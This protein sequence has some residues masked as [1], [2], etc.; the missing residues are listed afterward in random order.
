MR[1]TRIDCLTCAYAA[2]L[3]LLASCG[4]DQR[5]SDE[6]GSDL[7]TPD[8]ELYDIAVAD[9]VPDVFDAG[10]P[11]LITILA[12]ARGVFATECATPYPVRF[13]VV[14]QAPLAGV[15]LQGQDILAETGSVESSF[16]AVFGLNLITAE[17][18]TATGATGRDHRALLCGV[19]IPPTEAVAHASD[20][21]LGKKALTAI[22]HAGAR[23]FDELDLTTTFVEDNP[24]YESSLLIVDAVALQCDLGTAIEL[25]PAWDRLMTRFVLQNLRVA[26]ITELIG[27]PSKFYEAE[28]RMDK[29][30]VDGEM[31]L[32]LQDDGSI[33]ADLT[34]MVFDFEN[35]IVEIK[36]VAD[37]IL[38]VFPDY[39]ETLVGLIEEQL[40]ELLLDYV[41]GAVKE[42][43]THIGDPIPL[44][45][46]DKAFEIRFK[47]SSLKL[48]PSGVHL[49]LD[50]A[51]TG[52]APD[53]SITSPGV[54]NTPGQEE[55]PEVE[56]VRF[57]IKDDF[58]NAIFHEAWR[59]GMA[60]FTLDQ[61][62]MDA[63][64]LELTLVA[65]FL[66]DV[67]DKLPQEINPE[68]PIAV[69]LDATYPPVADMDIPVS[70]GVRLGA[71]D[72][73]LDVIVPSLSDTDP[74]ISFAV[75]LR[76]EGE[77]RPTPSD[78]IEIAMHAFDVSLDVVN[79]D[80][81]FSDAEAYLESTM[82]G[83]LQS[84]EPMMASLLG[85]IPLPSF[86]GFSLAN[87]HVGTETPNGGIVVI[88]G[89]I[90]EKAQ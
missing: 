42:A 77:V 20:L 80:G 85:S 30:I 87:L 41:P 39:K 31:F 66:G 13:N 37:D 10:P 89:D 1:T 60:R 47:P 15:T 56:G 19:Y 64:K 52:L 54:L 81:A 45:V 79:D 59:S 38:S 35:L 29:V 22:G 61:A 70:G 48:T 76:I 72:L 9:T 78:K 83:L 75:T 55:W 67:L 7:L 63:R 28:V 8:A 14:S 5:Q 23:W 68:A 73:M 82:D 84:L 49:A 32:K 58:L 51:V 43:L 34:D 27:N 33:V 46:L 74:I 88:T 44:E 36:G 71:G 4:D 53:P 86:G 3:V 69:V 26:V 24:L 17:A 62:F 40:A 18:S 2:F 11:P 90:V 21:Y 12:P 65:G 6:S 25:T 50:L 16:D 57:S